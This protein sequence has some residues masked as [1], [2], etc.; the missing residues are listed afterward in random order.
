M[1]FNLPQELQIIHDERFAAL[2][3]SKQGELLK[4]MM[5]GDYSRDL[6]MKLKPWRKGLFT[7][8]EFTIDAEWVSEKKWQRLL[9][10]LGR[11]EGREFLD[12]G[13]GNGFYMRKLSALG[14]SVTGFD[15]GPLN[16]LQ[17]KYIEKFAPDENQKMYLLGAEH[18][19]KVSRCFDG[20]LYMGVFYHH[21]DPLAQ[22]L[23]IR[24][25][26]KNK[27]TLYLET[28]GIAGDEEKI[29]IPGE[30]YAG[31]SNVW[32]LPTLKSLLKILERLKFIDIEVLSTSW[33]GVDEQRSTEWS[34][35]LS[36]KD[37]LDP[38]NPRRTIEGEPYPERFLIKASRQL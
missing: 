26:L 23:H 35:P 2:M 18:T 32:L 22:L 29:H 25:A 31:M 1:S 21:R 24:E 19:E 17:W 20:I 37:V 5:M 9:P 27:G 11:V 14:A 13:C 10:H 30:R 15:P 8:P 4:A 36:F 12:I 34:A 6:A 38:R 28:I 7:L 16:Y 3:Q 33:E